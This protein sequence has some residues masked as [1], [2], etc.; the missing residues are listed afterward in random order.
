LLEGNNGV[1]HEARL[2]SSFDKSSEKA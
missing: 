1:D 2:Y